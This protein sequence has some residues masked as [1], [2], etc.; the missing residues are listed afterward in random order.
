MEVYKIQLKGKEDAIQV[1]E[2][3][4][5]AI[6]ESNEEIVGFQSIKG[7][8]CVIN[9]TQIRSILRDFDQE[10]FEQEKY[11]HGLPRLP[12]AKIEYN[13]NK[14]EELRSNFL[15]NVT[16]A[17]VKI[18]CKDWFGGVWQIAQAIPA[19]LSDC[20]CEKEEVSYAQPQALN[21]VEAETK[22]LYDAFK[23][24]VDLS[25]IPY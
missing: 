16:T 5:R 25:Q 21:E 14:Y 4:M 23:N 7:E 17:K 19:H 20:R 22:E 6:T 18:N 2:P 9:K 10:K 1:Y 13:K 15:K 8:K 12:E 3:M 11:E 24:E